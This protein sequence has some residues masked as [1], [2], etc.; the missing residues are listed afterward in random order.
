MISSREAFEAERDIFYIE[1][2]G[3]DNHAN[4]LDN[5]RE[6]FRDVN[7]GLE[8][9][10]AEMKAQGMWDDVVLQSSSEFGRTMTSNGQGTDHAWGG[11]HFTIG[12]SVKGGVIRGEY[13]ELRVDGP[14][15]VSSTGQMLPSSPWE[16]VWQPLAQ[17][18]GVEDA[19]LDDVMPNLHAFKDDPNLLSR[20]DVFA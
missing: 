19:Y 7:A 4:V 3:F 12:G 17:W 11:N 5:V 2:G 16:S 9:F 14:Q 20:G 18:L 13:P 6:K 1:L 15:S 8:A 10:V